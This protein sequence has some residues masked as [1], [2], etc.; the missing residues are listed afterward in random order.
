MLI[1]IGAHVE[2]CLLLAYHMLVH[3][4]SMLVFVY[5]CL[6]YAYSMLIFV[7]IYLYVFTRAGAGAVPILRRSYEVGLS[8]MHPWA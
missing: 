1:L 3:A 7:Y 5:T 8:P 2:T 6:L 4:C